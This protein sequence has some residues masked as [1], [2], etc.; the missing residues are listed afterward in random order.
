MKQPIPV[1]VVS[2][3]LGSGKTTLLCGLLER[4]QERRLAVLINEIGEIS[5]DGALARASAVQE[6]P[7]QE[8]LAQRA[9]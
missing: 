5:I 3:F 1:T 2:G 8:A 4:R 7:V 9:R 6:A